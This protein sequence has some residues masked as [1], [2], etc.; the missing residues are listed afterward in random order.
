[1]HTNQP[2]LAI[3]GLCSRQS[4]LSLI[5]LMM[6][7]SCASMHVTIASKYWFT[8][9]LILLAPCNRIKGAVHQFGCLRGTCS[10]PRGAA[11]N[12]G[13]LLAR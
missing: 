10:T 12:P 1:M 4:S 9:L 7:P 8:T 2:S 13:E 3:I 11:N 6:S 5:T